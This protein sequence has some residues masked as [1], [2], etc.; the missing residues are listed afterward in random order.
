MFVVRVGKFIIPMVFVLKVLSAWG[1]DGSFNQ[2]PIDQSV[3]AA[4]KS[5]EICSYQT[6]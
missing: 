3:L 6:Q 5:C 4:R 2:Q 1:T